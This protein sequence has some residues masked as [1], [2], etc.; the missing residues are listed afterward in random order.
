MAKDKKQVAQELF[1]KGET[2]EEV[3]RRVGVSRR[4]IERWANE[5]NW[6]EKRGIV[7]FKPKPP[8]EKSEPPKPRQPKERKKID[9]MEITTNAIVVLD[10]LLSSMGVEDA[11]NV[12]GVASALVRFLEY[13]RKLQPKTAAELAELAIELN[14]RPEDFLAA[15][16]DEWRLR[17]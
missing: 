7:P 16:R 8:T 2:I 11:R 3:S 4:T 5:G 15:L 6:R 10:S 9:D 12:S 17:A 13:Y 1:N 14:L